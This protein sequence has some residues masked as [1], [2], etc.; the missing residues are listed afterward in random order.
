MAHYYLG[1]I[2]WGRG[3]YR[4][5]ADELESYLRATPNA[6]DA[7]RVRETIKELRSKS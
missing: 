1:G 5:A 7:Q 3:D 2:Y 4:H 6:Q